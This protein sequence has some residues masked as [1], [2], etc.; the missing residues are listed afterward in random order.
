MG[1]LDGDSSTIRESEPTPYVDHDDAI[2][3]IGPS[4]T[5]RAACL[6]ASMEL[7]ARPVQATHDNAGNMIAMVRPLVIVIDGW[8]GL[9]KEDLTDMAVSVGAQIV[10][11][12]PNEEPSALAARVKL[13]LRAARL[14]RETSGL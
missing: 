6:D 12:G 8:V 14:L 13:A 9:S 11:A 5:T 1:R 3:M 10:V 7:C 2:A 4:V